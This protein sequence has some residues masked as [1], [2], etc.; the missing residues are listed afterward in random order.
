MKQ[1]LVRA[2]MAKLTWIVNFLETVRVRR[3][4]VWHKRRQ[5]TKVGSVV[6]FRRWSLLLVQ[7]VYKGN[8]I[9]VLHSFVY[10]QES[11]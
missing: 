2:N 7:R 10:I 4:T 3:S 1:C 5:G 9:S 8:I 11:T 6:S